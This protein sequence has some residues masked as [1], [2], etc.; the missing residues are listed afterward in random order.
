MEYEL[1]RPSTFPPGTSVTLFHAE[2]FAAAELPTK[3]PVSGGLQTKVV[4]GK[5][6]GEKEVIDE[7]VTAIK[8]TE[9]EE[10]RNYIAIGVLPGAA[11]AIRH[12]R[13]VAGKMGKSLTPPARF[14]THVPG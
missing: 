8:F 11:K 5:V 9:V 4:G 1:N 3:G 2:D 14:P 7:T 12:L 6:E 10:G 13:F